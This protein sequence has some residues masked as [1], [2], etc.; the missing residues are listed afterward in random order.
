MVRR[1]VLCVERAN[2]HRVQLRLVVDQRFVVVI[3]MN[4]FHAVALHEFLG[5]AVDPVRRRD[6]FHVGHLQIAFDMGF[7]QSSRCR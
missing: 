5:L 1:G 6:D 2:A 4:A 7:P 3:E